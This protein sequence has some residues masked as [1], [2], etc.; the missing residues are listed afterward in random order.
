MASSIRLDGFGSG[1]D[2]VVRSNQEFVKGSGVQSKRKVT[3]LNFRKMYIFGGS[4]QFS[5]IRFASVIRSNKE[6][7]EV[8]SKCR[9]TKPNF[10]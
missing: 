2:S 4:V 5:V 1:L 7:V 10:Y 9:I 3:E 8:R 6:F